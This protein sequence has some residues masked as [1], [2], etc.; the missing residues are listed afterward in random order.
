MALIEDTAFIGV[1]GDDLEG[2]FDF[3]SGSVY[4]FTR[5]A[6]ESVPEPMSVWGLGAVVLRF[7]AWQRRQKRQ[8]R[9]N[10]PS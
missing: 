7:G 2:D 1:R 6:A 3:D 9:C 8:T 10:F 4:L 5:E